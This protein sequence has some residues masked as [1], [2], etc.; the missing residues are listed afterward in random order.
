MQRWK[1]DEPEYHPMIESGDGDYVLYAEAK[2]I[3][4]ERD[5]Y[6]NGQQ[7]VQAMLESTMD[8][9]SKW[10]AENKALQAEL[11]EAQKELAWRRQDARDNEAILDTVQGGDNDQR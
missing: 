6:R 7:Q 5:G 9:N 4:E 3:E 11:A 1:V 10:A 8:S 2:E